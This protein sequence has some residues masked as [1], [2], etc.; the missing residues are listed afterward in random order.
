[1]SLVGTVTTC[2]AIALF[3]DEVSPRFCFAENILVVCLE[4][5]REVKRQVV[6]LGE[7][8]LPSRIAQL[9]A[10]GVRVL[11][12]GAFHRA[13]LPSAERSGI[14]VITGISGKAEDALSSYL[15]G[16]IAIPRARQ[17]RRCQSLGP[18]SG[19][20]RTNR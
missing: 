14:K 11:L 4:R 8:W 20:R 1:L 17:R 15:A 5:G 3:G 16:A 18:S 10:I 12:C 19:R 13:F 7:P 6:S 9:A 2:L